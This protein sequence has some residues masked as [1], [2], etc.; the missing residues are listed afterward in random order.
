MVFSIKN[1]YPILKYVKQRVFCR[2]LLMIQ[3]TV[4]VKY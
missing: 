3:W 1:V 4:I 2:F